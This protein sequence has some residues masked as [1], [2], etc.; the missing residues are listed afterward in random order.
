MNF[1]GAKKNRYR[2]KLEG[3]DKDWVEAGARREAIYTNVEP[4]EYRFRVQA[5]FVSGVW[6]DG[7]ATLRLVITP[8]WWGTWYFRAFALLALFAF[9][10]AV[11]QARFYSLRKT[12]K[13]LE[14]RVRRRTQALSDTNA[15]LAEAN[16]EVQRQML[17]QYEQARELQEAYQ[18]LEAAKD[19]LVMRNRELTELN[20]EK[21]DLLGIVSHDL[22]N[23]LVSAL[24]AIKLLHKRFNALSDEQ[25][26]SYLEHI[27]SANEQMID[28]LNKLLSVNALETGKIAVELQA[29]D[30]V[31][32]CRSVVEAYRLRA[33]AKG[34]SFVMESSEP[35]AFALADQTL[36]PQAIDNLISNAVKYSPRDK[37]IYARVRRYAE[38]SGGAFNA[39]IRIE[40]EDEGPGFS[41]ED[42]AQLFN[43]FTRL[44]AR[45][46]GGEHSAGLGLSIV[47][48]MVDA[49]GGR[50]WCVDSVP[51]AGALFVMEFV[52][53]QAG[54]PR[55]EAVVEK[56]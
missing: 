9:G 7:E 34:L 10:Y 41:E 28:F 15:Q 38:K 12:A 48:K 5:S 14:E 16:E 31:A 55:E 42:R 20:K 54:A 30:A 11:A 46:T 3:F 36:L 23:P 1:V 50:V 39:T 25:K 18:K 27:Q 43:K 32:A 35:Q 40:I 37:K 13:L 49:M 44:S 6:S 4:G 56:T 26:F 53:V 24:L 19:A 47:K 21:N 29:C 22:R 17:Q 52:A 45:P 33:E 51:Q 8:P 2:Y